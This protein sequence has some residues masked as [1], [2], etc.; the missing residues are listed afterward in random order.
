MSSDADNVTRLLSDWSGGNQ[1]ALE[2]LLPLI[3]NELRRLA[4]QTTS[5]RTF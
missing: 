1:Q 2:Q 5:A 3:Y 4:Q